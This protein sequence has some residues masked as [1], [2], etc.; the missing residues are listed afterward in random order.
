M[1]SHSRNP[2]RIGI[3]HTII[4]TN[5]IQSVVYATEVSG[6]YDNLAARRYYVMLNTVNERVL[7]EKHLR[8]DTRT[9]GNL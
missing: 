7:R 5:S 4:S 6:T 8:F 3:V 2:Q 9:R 1:F